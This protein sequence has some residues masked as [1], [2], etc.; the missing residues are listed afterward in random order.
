MGDDDETPITV[1]FEAGRAIEKRLDRYLVDRIPFL[2]RT[3]LQRLIKEEAVTVNGRPGKASTTVRGGDRIVA[4]LPPPPSTELPAQEIP[5]E[6]LYEDED[7]VVINKHDDIIVHPARGNLSGTII[8]G[9]AWHFL[10]RSGG[11]L[12]RVG[13]EHARPG[14]VHRLDRHTT[15]VLLFAKSETA[16]WRLARQFE[17]RRTRKRYLAVV[18]GR[19]EPLA[20]VI[21]LPL[22]KHHTVREKYAV[23]WDETGK[24][25]VTVYHVRERYE[26]YTLLELRL[27]TGRTHQIRVHLSH[28]GWPIAGDDVYGGKAISVG[29]VAGPA[30]TADAG[31]RETLMGRAALH[32]ARLCISHPITRAPMTFDAPLPADMVNLIRLLRA[33]RFIDAPRVPGTELEI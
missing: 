27:E 6:I 13:Q 33:H 3:S 31:P 17:E 22:G 5:L 8:N 30:G 14:V 7:L 10:H 16:H 15:G 28:L 25:S 4:I 9:L 18:H 23:R 11:G 12:S 20:D 19:V 1:S 21:D 32:A 26:G 2:S 29:D 24:P